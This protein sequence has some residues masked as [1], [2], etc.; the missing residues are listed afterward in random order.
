M[1]ALYIGYLLVQT[2][3]IIG[4]FFKNDIAPSAVVFSIIVFII[5]SFIPLLGYPLAK[6]VGAKGLSNKPML[7]TFGVGIALLENSWFY[8]NWLVKGEDLISTIIVFGLF[9][10]VAFL[11]LKKELVTK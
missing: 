2:Y 10:I 1:I 5:W 11:P 4:V 7:F 3:S 6:L 9:F 8:F